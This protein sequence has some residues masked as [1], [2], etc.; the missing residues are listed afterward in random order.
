MRIRI[1]PWIFICDSCEFMWIYQQNC[2]KI[3]CGKQSDVIIKPDALTNK[4]K[5]E[6]EINSGANGNKSPKAQYAKKCREKITE[7]PQIP[8]KNLELDGMDYWQKCK[9]AFLVNCD[10]L[11]WYA[12]YGKYSRQTGK[13]IKECAQLVNC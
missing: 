9:S 1:L 3:Y 13:E 2:K 10:C 8:K 5:Q 11:L 4:C 12:K 6:N 7:I